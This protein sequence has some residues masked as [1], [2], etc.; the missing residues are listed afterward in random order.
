MDLAA[1]ISD[2]EAAI[3]VASDALADC[4]MREQNIASLTPP[5]PGAE[6]TLKLAEREVAQEQSKRAWEKWNH[7]EVAH[8]L[9]TD[10]K[11]H[12]DAVNG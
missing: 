1:L 7:L 11:S 3:E 9:L 8:M 6:R 10:A 4:H 12:L 2:V 5:D